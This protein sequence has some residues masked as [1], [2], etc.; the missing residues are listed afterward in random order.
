MDAEI[1]HLSDTL[2]FEIVNAIGL[3]R[4]RF[5]FR[6][7]HPLFIRATE[8][9]AT[10][11]VTL[12]RKIA[13][14]GVDQATGWALTHWC[15]DIQAHGME[16]VPAEGP[17]LVVSNHAGAYDSFLICSQ[18]R[19]KDFLVISSDIPFFKNLQHVS[20]HAVFLSEKIGDRMTATRTAIRHMQNPNPSG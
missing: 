20:E 18:M 2:I 5:W 14:E 9:M 13:A 16:N 12:N 3:P 10:I 15:R 1:K 17:V 8:R 19:R 7:F 11:G 6:V 4:N